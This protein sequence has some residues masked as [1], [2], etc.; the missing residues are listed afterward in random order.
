MAVAV[1]VEKAM[2]STELPFKTGDNRRKKVPKAAEV[3]GLPCDR[4]QCTRKVR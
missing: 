4:H 3:D 1:V 2:S